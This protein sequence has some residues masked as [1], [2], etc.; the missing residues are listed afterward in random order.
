MVIGQTATKIF[1]PNPEADQQKQLAIAN[2]VEDI[3][4]KRAKTEL[5]EAQ[6]DAARAGAILDIARMGIDQANYRLGAYQAVL[7]SLDA[8]REH[9]MNARAIDYD[10]LMPANTPPPPGALSELGGGGDMAPAQ[11]PQSAAPPS[12]PGGF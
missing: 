1:L 11:L 3:K 12:A 8:D 10:A 5:T 9:E 7:Q 4:A 6:S 2:A